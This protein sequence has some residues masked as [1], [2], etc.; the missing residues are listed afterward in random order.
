[1]IEPQSLIDTTITPGLPAPFWFIQFLKVLGFSLHEVPMN[2]WYAGIICSMILAAAGHPQGRR[3]SSRLMSQMPVLIALG[4]NFG[5]VPLLFIQVAY[6]KLFYPATILMAW[7]WLAVIVLLT[8]AYYGVYIYAFGLY[9]NERTMR[10]WKRVVGWISAVA[11]ILIGFIFANALTLTDNA[12]AWPEIWQKTSVGAAP[13]GTGLNLSDARLWPRWLMMFGMALTTTAAWLVVDLAWFGGRESDDYRR[14]APEFALRLYAVGAVWYW[15]TAAWYLFLT[16]PTETLRAMFLSPW[17]ILMVLTGLSP[18]GVGAM[19]FLRRQQAQPVTRGWAAAVG[20]AQFAMLLI[21][22]ISR[23]VV[24]NHEVSRYFDVAG[25]PVQTQWS[26]LV[27]FLVSLIAG[28]AGV[29][30]ML[31]QLPKAQPSDAAH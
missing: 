13:T 23:Q 10:R 12:A 16:W 24:Q 22:A 11:F 18:F 19:L 8:P 1:M 14:W 4:V 25:Q 28:I 31:A 20:L 21:N 29:A 27:V 5:I 6:S 15:V 17:A 2:L 7:F 26:S 3:F 30:W 9:D